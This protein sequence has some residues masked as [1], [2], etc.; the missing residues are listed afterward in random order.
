VNYYHANQFELPD[1]RLRW[2]D[3]P[4]DA[5]ML[6]FRSLLEEIWLRYRRPVFVGE[7][8]H[9]GAGRVKWIAEI[10]EEVLRARCSGVP[11]E[12]LCIYPVIDRPDWE[13]SNHWHHAGVWDMRL[14]PD[15][16]LLREVNSG[17][18]AEIQRLQQIL[19]HQSA[20]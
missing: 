2:E 11:V 5:R 20:C 15:G 16:S 12:G 19:P 4:R 18:A 10:A 17:Y 8:S 3:S 6:P 13:D 7:T 1:V 14:N 9:F